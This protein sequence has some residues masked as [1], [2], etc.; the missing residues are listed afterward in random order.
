MAKMTMHID[1]E[2]M[3][4]L[5]EVGLESDESPITIKDGY[6]VANLKI[7]AKGDGASFDLVDDISNEEANE[8]ED[9]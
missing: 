7:K 6:T 1:K 8:H 3:E 2:V 5:M 9:D 4:R